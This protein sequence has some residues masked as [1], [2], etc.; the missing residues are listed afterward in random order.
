[1]ELLNR[2]VSLVV[3]PAI[4]LV[5]TAGF[6]FF[7][8]GLVTFLFKWREG[9]DYK[10]GVQH[11]IWGMVGMLIMVSAAGIIRLIEDTI[12]ADPRNPDMSRIQNAPFIK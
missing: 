8:W 7:I 2:F 10:Q 11:M 5:F 1:M 4:Y 6:L 9:S 12:G 3:D